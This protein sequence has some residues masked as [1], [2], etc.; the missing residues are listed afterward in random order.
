ML[1]IFVKE[2][3][4]IIDFTHAPRFLL[5]VFIPLKDLTTSVNKNGSLDPRPYYS[6]KGIKR[7]NKV[8]NFSL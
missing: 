1:T 4:K 3:T 8:Q 6:N 7:L 5:M 2:K